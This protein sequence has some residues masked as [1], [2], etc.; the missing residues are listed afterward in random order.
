MSSQMKLW[1]EQKLTDGNRVWEVVGIW[2]TGQEVTAL[3]LK[4]DDAIELDIDINRIK[5]AIAAGKLTEI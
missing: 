1:K 3:D 4:E 2:M 5:T